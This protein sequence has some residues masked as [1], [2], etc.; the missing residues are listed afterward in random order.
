MIDCLTAAA[1]AIFFILVAAVFFNA[2]SDRHHQRRIDDKTKELDRANRRID[3]LERMLDESRAN[4]LG[5]APPEI[6][7]PATRPRPE[8]VIEELEQIDDEATRAEL[9]ADIRIEM[10][11]HPEQDATAIARRVIGG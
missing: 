6:S 3:A 9:E 8:G 10:E 11:A 7:A 4:V 1:A 5:V 2:S